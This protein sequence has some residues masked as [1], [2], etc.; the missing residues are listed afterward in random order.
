[1]KLYKK[2]L[3]KEECIRI[4]SAKIDMAEKQLSRLKTMLAAETK[5]SAGDKYETSRE[6]A[7]QE[8]DKLTF[9]LSENTKMRNELEQI[10]C[11]C[12]DQ[13]I[14]IGSLVETNMGYF[15]LA[16]ALGKIDIEGRSIFVLSSTAPI[17][18]LLMGKKKGESITFNDNKVNVLNIV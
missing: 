18:K 13:K 6:M 17:G 16:I 9:N 12:I 2:G 8:Q 7:K 15:Y 4:L 14:G 1:M 10:E 11:D 3:I 5:S